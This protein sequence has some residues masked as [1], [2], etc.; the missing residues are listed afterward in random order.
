VHK[1][2]CGERQREVEDLER[3]NREH[4]DAVADIGDLL[5]FKF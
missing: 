5:G 3:H 4:M 1:P 2:R